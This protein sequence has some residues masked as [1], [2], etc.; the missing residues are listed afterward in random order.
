LR[1]RA[2]G[3]VAG[4]TS[5]ACLLAAGA[6]GAAERGAIVET[7]DLLVPRPPATVRIAGKTQVVY[8][9]HITNFRPVD[10]SLS[11]LQVLRDDRPGV[12]VADYR[13]EEL[14]RRLGRP[15]VRGGREN[16]HVVGAGK[17]AVAYLWLELADPGP[18]PALRHRLELELRREEGP[19]PAVVEGASVRAGGEAA[20]PLAPPLRGGPW[21]A[22][23]DP[24]LMGGHRTA[25]YTLDGRARI[26]GRFAIDWIQLPPG[27]AVEKDETRR[28]ADWNGFGTEVLA[29]ADAIV[30][31]AMDDIPDNALPSGRPATP[32]KPEN[33]S[34]NYV[35]LD[36]GGGRFAFYEHLKHGSVAVKAGDRVKSGQVIGR[37]GNSGSTSIGP[38]LHFHV[39][40][41]NSLLGAEGLPFVFTRFEELGAFAS[42]EALDAGEKWRANAGNRAQ[43]R[44]L[45]HPRANSVIRFP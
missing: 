41:A 18:P 1:C 10:V 39:S 7:V 28:G 33:A 43:A 17:R 22:I 14:R 44:T 25:F 8:E 31:A 26:P 3:A 42:L 32:V 15:G 40:D 29:V 24:L 19:V 36:L 45:E 23:Y 16:A 38:H 4:L 27:G 13:D 9:L 21:T 11:R 37:L 34:G 2:P 30:A 5:L 12:S 6:A 20:G 35:A